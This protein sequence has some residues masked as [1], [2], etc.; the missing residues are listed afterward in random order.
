MLSNDEKARKAVLDAKA[1]KSPEEVKE[2]AAL[3][4]KE[5]VA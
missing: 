1:D 2:L 3:V 4:A 5:K